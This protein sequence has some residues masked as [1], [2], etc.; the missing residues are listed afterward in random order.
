MGVRLTPIRKAFEKP[1][2]FFPLNAL[3]C[4]K[5]NNCAAQS[6]DNRLRL[7]QHEGR[8]VENGSQVIQNR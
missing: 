1:K 5:L 2:E 4:N 8:E 3:V 6:L 7:S